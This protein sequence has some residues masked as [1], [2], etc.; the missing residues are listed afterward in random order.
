[1]RSSRFTIVFLVDNL[2]FGVESVS[3]QQEMVMDKALPHAPSHVTINVIEA[4]E[5]G[6]YAVGTNMVPIALQ[7]GR[8][9]QEVQNW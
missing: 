1:M 7:H 6:G 8:S 3:I 4:L 2:R 9:G 5:I